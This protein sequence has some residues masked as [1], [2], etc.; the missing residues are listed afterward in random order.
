[1]EGTQNSQSSSEQRIFESQHSLKPS[2]LP[3]AKTDF[4]E[5]VPAATRFA[6]KNGTKLWESNTPHV[7][8]PLASGLVLKYP[9]C[10]QCGRCSGFNCCHK[11]Q[12]AFGPHLLIYLQLHLV[13]TPEGHGEIRLHLGFKLRTGKRPPAPKNY[14]RRDRPV[15]PRSLRSTSLRKAK[16][17]TRLPKSPTS[18]INFSLGLPSLLLYR[19][20]HQAK[21]I[22]QL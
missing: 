12:A 17:Y 6:A 13:S 11:L 3:Q 18:T 14:H 4:S 16:G 10:L 22:W 1:M 5:P 15:T 8:P 21:A 2:Y 9:I 19:S 7:P 20:P